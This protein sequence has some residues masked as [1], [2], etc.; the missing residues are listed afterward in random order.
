MIE[1]SPVKTSEGLGAFF[2]RRIFLISL[3]TLM[4][5]KELHLVR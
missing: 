2:K 1:N 4:V 5:F 3:K